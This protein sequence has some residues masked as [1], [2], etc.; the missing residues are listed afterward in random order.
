MNVTESRIALL[1]ALHEALSD[2][3]NNGLPA[4]ASR[5]FSAPV[6]DAA[7]G[8]ARAWL[9]GFQETGTI[10]LGAPNPTAAGVPATPS[11]VTV[12]AKELFELHLGMAHEGAVTGLTG[13]GAPKQGNHFTVAEFPSREDSEPWSS[14]T[15]LTFTRAE[16][17]QPGFLERARE[18]VETMLE[19]EKQR[20]AQLAQ[21]PAL[22]A[23]YALLS[24]LDEALK[25]G[26][27]AQSEITCAK[28]PLEPPYSHSTEFSADGKRGQVR[29]TNRAVAPNI[30]WDIGFR[31]D[32]MPPADMNRIVSQTIGEVL[33][34][35]T[36]VASTVEVHEG[37][38]N[39]NH[40]GGTGA[41]AT[42]AAQQNPEASNRIPLHF[43]TLAGAENFL[44]IQERVGELLAETNR[45]LSPATS[46]A[47]ARTTPQAN[48]LALT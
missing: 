35:F 4:D 46:P 25:E 31:M 8:N 9:R 6:G 48:T 47:I 22:E 15:Q 16:L 18:A 36:A 32:G 39:L 20:A 3:F 42:S 37:H 30:S 27:H 17:E 5:K 38:F 2:S 13:A 29:V 24:M 43:V 21:L 44:D 40:S 28:H 33:E 26:P 14:A 12:L 1:T 19:S 11:P 41:G 7:A 45:Q 23:R 34:G 10:V